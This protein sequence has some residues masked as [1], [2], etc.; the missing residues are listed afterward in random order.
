MRLQTT[1]AARSA[2]TA[3][4]DRA[5][6]PSRR[7]RRKD[8]G[9]LPTRLED[10]AKLTRDVASRLPPL[11]GIFGQT[12]GDQMVQGRRSDRPQIDIDRGRVPRIAATTL[13]DC[14]RQ[15]LYGRSP[16]RRGPRRTRTDRCAR[17]F[18]CLRAAPAPCSGACRRSPLLPRGGRDRWR[19]WPGPAWQATRI[20][21]RPLRQP[22]S[23]SFASDLVRKCYRA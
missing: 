1:A 15:T 19:G 9:G 8:G 11:V 16:F 20:G 12:R 18:S 5:A 23:S 7:A 10:P 14:S 4:H 3:D 6:T 13:A 2:T 21:R 22:E 17:R